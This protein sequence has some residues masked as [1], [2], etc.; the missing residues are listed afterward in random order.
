MQL[1]REKISLDE[2]K[3]MA[4][5]MYNNLVKAV[6]DIEKDIMIVDAGLHADQEEALLESGSAQENLWGINLHPVK[7]GSDDFIEF[8][9]MINIRPSQGNFYR[10]VNDLAIQEKIISIVKHLVCV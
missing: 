4:Q 7:F 10:G 3:K 2:L 8:D 5:K 1:V 9:S 6:V